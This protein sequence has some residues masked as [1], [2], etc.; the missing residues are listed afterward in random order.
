MKTNIIV[1]KILKSKWKILDIQKIKKIFHQIDEDFTDKQIYKKIYYLKNQW[2]ILSIKKDIFYI[3]DFNKEVDIDEII[4]NNYW[5]FLK[6][7]L[8]DNFW[9]NY[10]I[11]WIK[12]LEIHNNIY[13]IPDKISIINPYKQSK[14]VLLKWKYILNTKYTIKWKSNEKSF[15]FFKKNTQK[16]Y[17]DWKVFNISWYELSLLESIYSLSD[18]EKY[19]IELIKKNIRKNHKKIDTK[20]FE[21]FLK[22]GKYGSS[23]KKIYELSLWINPIF[24]EKIK[25]ILKKWYW[26]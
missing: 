24:A 10:F 17:I 6:K 22:Y 13:S 11:W 5:K 9:S 8:N 26:M 2:Y 18:D 1:K 25:N 16:E 7:Y 21:E 12:A 4:E 23:L 15:K 19:I 3:K 20:I 14:Q